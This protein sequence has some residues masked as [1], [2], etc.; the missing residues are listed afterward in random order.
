MNDQK[1]LKSSS[2]K[3]YWNKL[4]AVEKYKIMT[5]QFNDQFWSSW[6]ATVQFHDGWISTVD[7]Y[8]MIFVEWY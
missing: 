8:V 6:S 1:V 3:D 2:A 5:V 7:K 4:I